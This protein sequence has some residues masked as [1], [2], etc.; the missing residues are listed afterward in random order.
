MAHKPLDVFSWYTNCGVCDRGADYRAK[1]HDE[2]MLM[3]G[4][5]EPGCGVVWDSITTGYADTEDIVKKLRPDLEYLE[6]LEW[7]REK[8]NLTNSLSNQSTTK[9]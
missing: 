1:S 2:V 5:V 8:Y 9:E 6:Y 3:S 4:K 7:M